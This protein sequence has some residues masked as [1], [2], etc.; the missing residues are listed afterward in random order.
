MVFPLVTGFLAAF[1]DSITVMLFFATLTYELSRLLKF[2]AIRVVVAE[3]CLANIGGA[4]TLVGD[5]PNIMI[6]SA[7]GLSFM[8]FLRVDAV[9]ALPLLV[10]TTFIFALGEICRGPPSTCRGTM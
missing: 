4:S 9:I 7:T 6:G 1:M 2:D 10:L 5:P 3:V 8:D